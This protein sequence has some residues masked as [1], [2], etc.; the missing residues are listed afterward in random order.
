MHYNDL[1]GYNLSCDRFDDFA[2][3]DPAT[4]L[5]SGWRLLKPNAYYGGGRDSGLPAQPAASACARG[6]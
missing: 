4:G 5:P 2:C 3:R 6:A 1:W